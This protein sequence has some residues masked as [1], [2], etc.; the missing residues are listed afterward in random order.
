M[1][2]NSLCS[3]SPATLAHQ[4]LHLLHFHCL[5]LFPVS[6]APLL[7]PLRLPPSICIKLLQTEIKAHC[8]SSLRPLSEGKIAGKQRPYSRLP[9]ITCFEHTH[10]NACEHK[11]TMAVVMKCENS[12]SFR[13]QKMY[14]K[15]MQLLIISHSH[16]KKSM[17]RECL[18][19]ELRVQLCAL[20]CRSRIWNES[21][22]KYHDEVLQR[23][24][25][26]MHSDGKHEAGGENKNN[27][28]DLPQRHSQYGSY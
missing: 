13:E 9:Q 5:V 11:H 20:W 19:R 7:L 26:W 28:C 4:A 25:I 8:E 14:V 27:S 17:L 1:Q 23:T 22:P 6:I 12:K 18:D 2:K 21:Q 15:K 16:L 10:A 24:K 3:R